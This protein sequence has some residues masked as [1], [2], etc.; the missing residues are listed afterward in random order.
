[1][2]H[3]SFFGGPKGK[4]FIITQVYHSAME[5]IA[6]EAGTSVISD[7]KVGDL[8]LISYGPTGTDE[9]SKNMNAD[10]S[11][12]EGRKYNAKI[13]EKKFGVVPL[14]LNTE[15]PYE[16]LYKISNDNG[17][18]EEN[19]FEFVVELTAEAQF[20]LFFNQDPN[21]EPIIAGSEYELTQEGSNYYLKIPAPEFEYE[22]SQGKDANGN[23]INYLEFIYTA[24][25]VQ[26]KSGKIPMSINQLPISGKETWDITYGGNT[27]LDQAVI[28]KIGTEIKKLNNKSWYLINATCKNTSAPDVITGYV[29]IFLYVVDKSIPDYYHSIVQS[30]ASASGQNYDYLSEE[31]LEQNNNSDDN[32]NLKIS[33]ALISMG[34]NLEV[35]LPGQIEAKNTDFKPSVIDV[36]YLDPDDDKTILGYYLTSP[37][38]RALY[39]E[40]EK[41]AG[42]RRTLDNLVKEIQNKINQVEA[43]TVLEDF[44]TFNFSN[45]NSSASLEKFYQLI[46]TSS[47]YD[48]FTKSYNDFI[49]PKYLEQNAGEENYNLYPI[50][51]EEKTLKGQTL[52]YNTIKI[53]IKYKTKHNLSSS[54]YFKLYCVN[55]DGKDVIACD[56]TLIKNGIGEFIIELEKVENNKYKF[57]RREGLNPIEDKW[58]TAQNLETDDLTSKTDY[59]EMKNDFINSKLYLAVT[60]SSSRTY[61]RASDT[62]FSDFSEHFDWIKIQILGEDK[63]QTLEV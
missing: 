43:P 27:S 63:I 61:S 18:N 50:I 6:N 17:I 45:P 34:K 10:M 46:K 2:L 16:I 4:D 1:M 23:T 38:E 15:N 47:S 48:I 62:Y 28:G 21:Q 32:Q 33:N 14:N 60:T 8:V 40:L 31:G 11:V 19:Y 56:N 53:K 9:Y 52:Q 58:Y 57:V 20:E 3:S 12:L 42:A 24:N 39:S 26:A 55:G 7:L 22:S 51:F 54:L 30:M 41:E 59:E 5:L 36:A 49:N 37:A 29:T 13:Y 25:N 35:K 44:G